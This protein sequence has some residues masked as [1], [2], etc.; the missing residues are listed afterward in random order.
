MK[1][2]GE[3]KKFGFKSDDADDPGIVLALVGNTIVLKLGGLF[4]PDTPAPK[5]GLHEGKNN[6][7]S[8]TL[9]LRLNYQSLCWNRD[10][11]PS[12]KIQECRA[13]SRKQWKLIL[14]TSLT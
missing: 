11:A 10:Y 12:L 7:P 9:H 6:F 5:V 14:I 13:D 2:S 1:S 4:I 3:G 8:L